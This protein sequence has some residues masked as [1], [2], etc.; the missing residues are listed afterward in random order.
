MY[1]QVGDIVRL[2]PPRGGYP[3]SD[4][5]RIF[6]VTDNSNKFKIKVFDIVSEISFFA[7]PHIFQK[8][9]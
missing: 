6:V 1:F 3:P 7:K 8:V 5:T 4:P 9:S 2:I